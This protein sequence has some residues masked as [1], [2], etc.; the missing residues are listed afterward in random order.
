MPYLHTA[1]ILFAHGSRDPLWAR[2]IE[3]LAQRIRACAP[4][5]TVACAYLELMAPDLQQCADTLLQASPDLQ[6]IQILPVFFGMGRHAREDLPDLCEQLRQQHP[7]VLLEILPAVGEQVAVLDAIA[8]S[9][10]TF[11]DPS[12][13]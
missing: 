3:A 1:L 2:P 5:L 11:A 10:L 12:R 8:R 6:R 4:D 7:Q 13:S 9:A